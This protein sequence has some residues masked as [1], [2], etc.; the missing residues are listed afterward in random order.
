VPVDE[1]TEEQEVFVFLLEFDQVPCAVPLLAKARLIRTTS[2]T[3]MN[4]VLGRR[5]GV[6]EFDFDLDGERRAM[7]E[8]LG[9]PPSAASARRGC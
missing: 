2:Y 3:E 5:A 4:T 6:R 9:Q 1:G 8:L 7:G